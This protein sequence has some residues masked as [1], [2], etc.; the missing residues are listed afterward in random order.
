MIKLI[1]FLNYIRYFIVKL[2]PTY[3][4]CD[5]CYNIKFKEEEIICWKCGLGEMIYK[6]EVR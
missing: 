4:V 6:G 1:K 5:H 3:Y 2:L